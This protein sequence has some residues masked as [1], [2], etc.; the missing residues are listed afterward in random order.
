MPPMRLAALVTDYR[1]GTHADVLLSKFIHGF[2]CDEPQVHAVP[3]SIGAADHVHCQYCRGRARG[4]W[5][6]GGGRICR[7]QLSLLLRPGRGGMHE[8]Y[9][10]NRVGDGSRVKEDGKRAKAGGQQIQGQ[11]H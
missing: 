1:P 9:G 10:G 3:R 4:R 5:C 8:P 7:H 11:Q 6:Q 2:P